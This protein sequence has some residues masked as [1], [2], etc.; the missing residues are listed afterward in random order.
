MKKKPEER[1]RY[2]LKRSFAILNNNRSN[3]DFK[4]FINPNEIINDLEYSRNSLVGYT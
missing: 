4:N 3:L 2:L 1:K